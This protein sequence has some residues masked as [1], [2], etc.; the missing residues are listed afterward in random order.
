VKTKLAPLIANVQLSV[1]LIRFGG[2]PDIAPAIVHPPA[3]LKDSDD[4]LI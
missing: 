2:L 3:L 1:P 4:P